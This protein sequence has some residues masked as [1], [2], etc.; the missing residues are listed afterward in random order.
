MIMA[1]QCDL[2]TGQRLYLENRGTQTVVRLTSGSDRQQQSQ[3]SNF[4][5]GNWRSPP[6]V[7]R[8]ATEI[9]LRIDSAQ[10]QSFLSLQAQRIGMLNTSPDLTDADVLPLQSTESIASSFKPIE[11]MKPMQMGDMQMQPMEMKMG[12]MHM[13]M[14]APDAQSTHRFCAQCGESVRES[15]RFCSHCGTKLA[16]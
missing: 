3:Q 13:K 4:E 8:T 6:K 2:E 16:D 15:D 11:P 5:T 10:K 14:G 12:T 7:F 1:Y 9:I